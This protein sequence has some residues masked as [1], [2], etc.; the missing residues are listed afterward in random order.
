MFIKRTKKKK[1]LS[2]YFFNY[3]VDCFSSLGV[4]VAGR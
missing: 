4:F 1:K 3:A 2:V